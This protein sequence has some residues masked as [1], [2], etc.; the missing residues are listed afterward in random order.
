MDLFT[1]SDLPSSTSFDITSLLDSASSIGEAGSPRHH[2]NFIKFL[3]YATA[4]QLKILPLAWE[5][6][7]EAL[8]PNGATAKVNQSFL[9]SEMTLVYKR[10]KSEVT[11]HRLSEAQ[12]RELQYTAMINELII[13]AHPEIGGHNSI[14]RFVGICFELSPNA[15]EVWPILVLLKA[16][17]GDLATYM[18]QNES[19]EPAR[20]LTLC[21]EIAKGV[22]RV[23]HYGKLS[24]R[25]LVLHDNGVDLNHYLGVI[26]GDINPRNILVWHDV[27]SDGMAVVLA[28]FGFSRFGAM[29]DLVKLARS[30][31]WDAPEWHPRE[32]KLKDTKKMDVYSFGIVCLWLFFGNNTLLDLGLPSTTVK[33]AFMGGS[34]DAI[35]RIQSRKN[36][37]DSILEWALKLLAKKT[38]LDGEIRHR[39]ERVFTLALA[40]DPHRRPSSMEALIEILVDGS[41]EVT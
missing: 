2:Q 7:L 40:R 18:T 3:Q 6:A 14:V 1:T 11:D 20:L 10:F 35:A 17:R 28:D 15:V 12:F 27:Q 21:G 19:L 41:S 9:N 38:D 26:H 32:F 5:P 37:N 8:G 31:P 24:Y 13:L 16:T 4:L 29:D 34:L 36:D 30:E 39:L 25:W 33:T 23:H 22:H